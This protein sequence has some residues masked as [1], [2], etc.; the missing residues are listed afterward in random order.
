MLHLTKLIECITPR[1][2]PDVNY[3][4][5]VIMVCQCRF[6][7]CNKCTIS[8]EVNNS[9]G[10]YACVGRKYIWEISIPSFQFCCKPKTAL[11][12]SLN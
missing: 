9:E 3:G 10:G 8:V 12:K 5:W 2:N 7:N 11:K 4:L 6:I 1:V